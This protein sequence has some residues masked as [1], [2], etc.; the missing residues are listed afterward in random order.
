MTIVTTTTSQSVKTHTNNFKHVIKLSI[1]EIKQEEKRLRMET[2]E[3]NYRINIQNNINDNVIF[4]PPYDSYTMDTCAKK[5]ST[6]RENIVK[7]L[8]KIILNPHVNLQ[9]ME[10][11]SHNVKILMKSRGIMCADCVGILEEKVYKGDGRKETIKKFYPRGYDTVHPIII[12]NGYE[13]NKKFYNSGNGFK[14]V[15]YDVGY[16]FLQ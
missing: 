14:K 15:F 12:M 4:I 11:E 9:N 16:C 7:P 6:I 2:L 5:K 8:T 3:E 13:N 10:L 1:N